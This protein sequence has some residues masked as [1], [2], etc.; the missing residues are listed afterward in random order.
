MPTKITSENIDAIR[1][2]DFIVKY[3]NFGHSVDEFD[4]SE[5]ERM[6]IM[7]VVDIT[8]DRIALLLGLPQ[9]TTLAGLEVTMSS[10]HKR[11]MDIVSDKN[12]WLISSLD[13]IFLL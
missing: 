4:N 13:S 9:N 2:G 6:S 12:W 1:Q 3:P 5:Q 8:D 7:K 11:K 10:I